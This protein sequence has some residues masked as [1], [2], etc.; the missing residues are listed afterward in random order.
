MLH[1]ILSPYI[2]GY[3]TN[4]AHL[5][6][7]VCVVLG[8]CKYGRWVIKF[9]Y[10]NEWNGRSLVAVCKVGDLARTEA[11]I[12]FCRVDVYV[13][14]KLVYRNVCIVNIC[15]EKNWEIDYGLWVELIVYASVELFIFYAWINFNMENGH[16][17]SNWTNGNKNSGYS[18]IIVVLEFMSCTTCLR[19]REFH[20]KKTNVCRLILA[21][22]RAWAGRYMGGRNS[23][24]L[25]LSILVLI[26]CFEG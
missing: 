12:T 6:N 21:G 19:E 17:I 22:W 24:K 20:F 3:I 15:R 1:P 25:A 7:L 18:I 11:T 16:L 4:N 2:K 10:W 13:V 14:T 26:A 23:V 5:H 9:T 8:G